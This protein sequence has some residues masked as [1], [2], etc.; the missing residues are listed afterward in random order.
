MDRYS[1]QELYKNIGKKGQEKLSESGVCIIG[2]GAL[3]GIC[4]ELLARAGIGR[5]RIIDRDF[6]EITNLQRQILFEE[7]DIGK[8]KAITAAKKLK[9]INSKIRIETQTDDLTYQNIDALIG[10]PD[11]ILACTDNMESRFLINDYSLKNKIPWIYGAVIG[12]KGSIFVIDINGPCFRCIFNGPDIE[13]CDTSGILN[14]ASSLI[15][16][17]MANE[18]IKHLLGKKI[19]KELI[20][21]NLWTN[22]FEKYKV[23]KR[24]MCESCNRKFQYLTGE[25]QTKIVKICGN[26][27]FQ[28]KTTHNFLQLKE[29]LEKTDNIKA[30]KELF[31]FKNLTI[32]HDGRILIKAESEK[33]ARSDYSKYIGN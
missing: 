15:G 17:M 33:S 32:F 20:Y 1:S 5:I 29:K 13:T 8:A 26:G 27:V 30:F 18:A 25:K 3:G 28:F 2:A 7:K 9:K 14:T 11:L 22:N 23:K 21:I 4:C 10:N 6:I 16:S 12:E 19:E 24:K 31:H